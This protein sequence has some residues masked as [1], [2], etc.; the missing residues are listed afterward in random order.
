MC[1]DRLREIGYKICTLENLGNSNTITVSQPLELKN[2]TLEHLLNEIVAQNPGYHWE[3]VKDDLVNIFPIQSVLDTKVPNFNIRNK[4]AWLILNQD[5]EIEKMG[6]SLF[7]E[8]G[9]E[10]GPLI[11]LNLESTDLRGALNT[12]VS[13]LDKAI[14][15]IS[16]NPGAY[17]LT[18]SSIPHNS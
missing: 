4:G 11:S 13:Q 14:W 16:G 6:I 2:T 10:K 5:L 1:A 18:I 3:K 8:F 15:H 9:E 7:N 17:F 12:I